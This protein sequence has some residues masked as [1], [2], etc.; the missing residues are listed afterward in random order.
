MRLALAL[1]L[2]LGCA[3]RVTVRDPADP[4]SLRQG[5][6]RVAVTVRSRGSVQNV[7]VVPRGTETQ[8]GMSVTPWCQTPCSLYLPSGDYALYTGSPRVRD[9]V[10]PLRVSADPLT[11]TARA[12]SRASWERGRNLLV[13]G[14]GLAVVGGIFLAFSPLEV[15]GGSPTGVETIVVGASVSALGAALIAVGARVMG[16]ERTGVVVAPEA[17]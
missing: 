16:A 7:A 11:V 6:G 12:P 8:Q 9:A 15:T 1:S 3:S 2:L 5:E 13:G 4:A 10:S 14:V 17:R